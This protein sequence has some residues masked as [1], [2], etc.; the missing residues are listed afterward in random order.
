MRLG[1]S[2]E[3]TDCAPALRREAEARQADSI[4]A[5][6]E[7]S[8]TAGAWGAGLLWVADDYRRG[9]GGSSIAGPEGSRVTQAGSAEQDSVSVT[10]KHLTK[11]DPA[12]ALKP[13]QVPDW[14]AANHNASVSPV[15]LDA[16]ISPT[17]GPTDR[18]MLWL[19]TGAPGY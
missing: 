7:S 9:G 14:G 19:K 4:I 1:F 8:G 11:R 15:L 16:S 18:D 3:E 2:A 12:P 10:K 13:A 5:Q 17:D 6:V